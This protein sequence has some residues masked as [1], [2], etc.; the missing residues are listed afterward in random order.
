M[1]EI[2][3]LCQW[4]LLL[5]LSCAPLVAFASEGR[6]LAWAEQVSSVRS[7]SGTQVRVRGVISAEKASS[8]ELKNSTPGATL[9]SLVVTPRSQKD[10]FDF[11]FRVSSPRFSGG[12]YFPLAIEYEAAG[13]LHPLT[14]QSGQA[15]TAHIEVIKARHWALLAIVLL[16]VALGFSKFFRQWCDLLG[17]AVERHQRKLAWGIGGL[18]LLLVA[19]GWTGS[20][21][22]FLTTTYAGQSFVEARGSTW[23][24]RKPQVDRWDEWGVITPSVLAQ[25]HHEPRFPVV[26]THIGPEGQNMGVIGMFGVPVAQWAA[27][28]RPATWGYFVLPLRHAMSW[29]WQIQFWG[30]LLAVW[31]LLNILRTGQA[32]RNLALS[33]VFCAAPYA[34]GWSNWSLYAS[35]FP[36]LAVCLTTHLLRSRRVTGAVVTGFALGW[37]LACWVLVLYPPWLVIMGSLC[38]LIMVGWLLDHR[39]EL[40]WSR[41]QGWAALAALGTAALLLGSW[42][43]DTRDAVMQVQSTVYPGG[44]QAEL[45]GNAPLFWSLRG[46]LGLEAFAHEI[47]PASSKPE[48]SSYFF[49]PLAM[50]ATLIFG[51]LRS[52]RPRALWMCLTAFVIV[53]TWYAFVGF[54]LWLAQ[55]SKWGVLTTNRMDLGLGFA[56]VVLA[57]LLWSSASGEVASDVRARLDKAPGFVHA[58]VGGVLALS[59]AALAWWVLAHSGADLMPHNPWPYRT[60]IIVM[61]AAMAWWMWRRQVVG[62]ILSMLVVSIG[63]TLSYTPISKA[64]RAMELA[65]DVRQ[66]VSLENGA[67]LARTLVVDEDSFPAMVLAAMGV[68]VINGAL[69][70]PHASMWRSMKLPDDQWPVVNRYQHLTF[71]PR[72]DVDSALHYRV[73]APRMDAVTVFF[74]PASFDFAQ[75]GAKRVVVH[76]NLASALE[77]SPR[78]ERLGSHRQSVWFRVKQ[79]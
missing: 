33:V 48:V 14:F 51:V 69:Y 28:A 11:E 52:P 32:G 60:S 47:G 41:C 65:A 38:G 25:I 61:C 55:L 29:Q 31:W 73:A 57:C 79:D 23:Q 54:P 18:A 6:P 2:K 67:E 49:V 8:V 19:W 30:C 64:P 45:G 22:H 59:S 3:N 42:W 12:G 66:F 10:Q 72:S 7:D 75:T 62:L 77:R 76:E 20:S 9:E 71:I 27:I 16:T 70:H 74:E 35:M 50:A 78:L 68:P 1:R 43:A 5:V 44:R 13:T 46:Y 58:C 26:N 34:A 63:T 56:L 21:W 40:V 53:Y 36:I 24:W 37:V 4:L 39:Q 17:N 15:L